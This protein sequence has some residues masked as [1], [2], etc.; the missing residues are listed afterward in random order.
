M[1]CGLEN[2]AAIDSAQ[3]L[4]SVAKIILRALCDE[5]QRVEVNNG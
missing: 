2:N 5:Q 4:S 3:K 1:K